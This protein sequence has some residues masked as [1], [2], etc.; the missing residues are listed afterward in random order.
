[1]RISMNL[2]I[3]LFCFGHSYAQ[4][5]D[6]VLKVYSGYN[7]VI[8]VYS[9]YKIGSTINLD[10]LPISKFELVQIINSVKD[11]VVVEAINQF[12]KDSVF[13]QFQNM[14]YPSEY[15]GFTY[16]QFL[17]LNSQY[18]NSE[19]YKRQTILDKYVGQYLHKLN[20]LN[21]SIFYYDTTENGEFYIYEKGYLFHGI[22][23]VNFKMMSNPIFYSVLNKHYE[24]VNLLD[25]NDDL[26]GFNDAYYTQ[27]III[28]IVVNNEYICD[29][30][31]VFCK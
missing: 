20:L 17:A 27:T 9:T 10:S 12:K 4:N 21:L 15:E 24:E 16:S 6:C 18:S 7:D 11:S 23:E 30:K 3:S 8:S 31:M 25:Y 1:M 19:L 5:D 22:Y 29:L 14:F 13:L 2:I 28:P 26:I